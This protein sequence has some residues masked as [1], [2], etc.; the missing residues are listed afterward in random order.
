MASALSVDLRQRMVGAV[1][2]WMSCR[3]AAVRFGVGRHRRSA[4][5]RG[6]VHAVI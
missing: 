6:P 4:E 2:S 5:W 3:A 1:A